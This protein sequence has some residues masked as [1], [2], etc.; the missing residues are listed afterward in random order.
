VVIA[1]WTFAGVH[2]SRRMTVDAHLRSAMFT[3]TTPP[4]HVSRPEAFD[5][6]A[7]GLDQG[8]AAGIANR[9]LFVCNFNS[10]ISPFVGSG[11]ALDRQKTLVGRFAES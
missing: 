2:D 8:E 6:V 3:E 9:R 7:K 1:D 10:L 5:L 4:T 11:N